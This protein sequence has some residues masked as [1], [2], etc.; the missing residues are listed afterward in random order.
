MVDFNLD[1]EK[2]KNHALQSIEDGAVTEANTADKAQV[3]QM[4]DAAL[5]TE[6]VCVLRYFQHAS[7]ATGIYSEPIRKHFAEHARQE[8]EHALEIAERI[9]QLGGEPNLDPTHLKTR[10]HSKYIECNSLSD[11]LKENLV[12]ERIAIMSYT[13]MIRYIGDKDPTTRRMLEG[14]LGVEEEHANELSDLLA[15]FDPRAP[16]H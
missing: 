12:N 1:I 10:A 5:A 2:I 16:L 15:A 3:L 8:Q 14:I 6:W 13:E 4:L 7:V 11:M 9:Q